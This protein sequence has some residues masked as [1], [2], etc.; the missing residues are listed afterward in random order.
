MSTESFEVS[1]EKAKQ[2]R[3]Y[4]DNPDKI[5]ENNKLKTKPKKLSII[6]FLYR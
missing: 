4:L 1:G 3:H 6:E 5:P 2:I